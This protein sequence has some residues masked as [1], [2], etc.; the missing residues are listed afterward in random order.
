MMKNNSHI[1]TPVQPFVKQPEE[2]VVYREFLPDLRLQEYIYCY[3][4]LKTTRPLTGPFHYR[5]V[6]DG[7]MDIFFELHD[8]RQSFIM[9]FS[10]A[11]TCFPLE[12]D[13]NYAGIRFLPGMFPRLF[14]L[15]AAELS[16]QAIM[17]GDVAPVVTR[18]L[19]DRFQ[20]GME[21]EQLKTLLDAFLLDHVTKKVLPADNR[22]LEAVDLIIQHSGVIRLEKELPQGIS[23]R[24]LRRLFEFY[25][26]D[27]PKA[28]S[29]VVRF[30]KILQS[31]HYPRHI[32]RN[33]S[34]LD[35]GYYDQTHF[36]KEFKTLYGLTPAKVFGK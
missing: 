27:T 34:Y 20:E 12:G 4:Q 7:C 6:A 26:G 1:Y 22:L 33:R 16:K 36:I 35:A 3:W 17:L 14:P 30:Q 5:V 25:I 10:D 8:P 31:T 15:N 28:F 9:G 23:S 2:T 13:F 32:R 11:Y 24:Q 21:E 29:K 18:F 19:V